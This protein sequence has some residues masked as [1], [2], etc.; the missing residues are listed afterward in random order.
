MEKILFMKKELNEMYKHVGVVSGGDYI[1]GSKK[2][3]K[4]I[5][6]IKAEKSSKNS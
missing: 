5:F 3:G 6:F 4:K 2:R 1:Q